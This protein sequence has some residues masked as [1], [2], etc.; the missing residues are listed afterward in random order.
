MFLFNL[1]VNRMCTAEV[2]WRGFSLG[3]IELEAKVHAKFCLERDFTL[4]ARNTDI[5]I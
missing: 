2:L 3:L 1:P 4:V 5:V